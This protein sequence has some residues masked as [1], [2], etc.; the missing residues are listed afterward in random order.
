MFCKSYTVSTSMYA[1][2]V[3]PPVTLPLKFVCVGAVYLVALMVELVPVG[4]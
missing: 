1:L 4:L 2:G 3:A